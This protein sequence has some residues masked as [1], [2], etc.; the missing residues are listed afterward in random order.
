MYSIYLNEWKYIFLTCS[1]HYLFM[2]WTNGKNHRKFMQLTVRGLFSI[3][4][5]NNAIEKFIHKINPDFKNFQ[6][7]TYDFL[8]YIVWCDVV[9]TDLYYI[10]SKGSG[11]IFV[12]NINFYISSYTVAI[13]TTRHIWQ[14]MNAVI[15]KSCWQ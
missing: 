13:N 11:Q 1:T 15:I 7:P 5:R 6:L 8:Y 10:S 14:I 2:L 4:F 3:H 12:W 9:Q